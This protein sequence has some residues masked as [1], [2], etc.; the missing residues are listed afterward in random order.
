MATDDAIYTIYEIRTAPEWSG[1]EFN[2]LE[3]TLL[4]RALEA[5]ENEGLASIIKT[6]SADGN[7]PSIDEI[8]VKFL[9]QRG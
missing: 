4:L 1:N 7:L 9:E 2:S 5:L 6:P 8:G 3:L